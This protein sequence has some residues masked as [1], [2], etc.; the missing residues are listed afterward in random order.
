[1]KAIWALTQYA[2]FLDRPEIK[3]EVLYDIDNVKVRNIID[4]ARQDAR[5]VLLA[6]EAADVV[7]AYGIHTPFARLAT[8]IEEAEKYSDEVGYPVV[9]K[10]ASP[11]ILHKSDVGGVALN[12]KS[13]GEAGF[14]YSSILTRVAR[15]LPRA[16]V[17][18]VTVGKMVE[19]GMELII[20]VSRDVQFGPLIMFGLGGIYISF[21]QDVSFRL[22]PLSIDDAREMISETKAFSILRGVRGARPS[23]INAIINTLI[24]VSQL[25]VDFPEILEMDINPLFVYEEGRGCIAIDV[26]ITLSRS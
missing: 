25:V 13:A 16:Q 10:V 21:L 19:Q 8:S 9:L 5:V 7:R 4:V 6:H 12:I 24:R 17:Y 26:K 14:A 20:G 11:E 22:A 23:D 1:M 3:P 15:Y 18:G 2:A